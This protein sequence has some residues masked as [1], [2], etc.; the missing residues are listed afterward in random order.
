M[1]SK[2]FV[3]KLENFKQYLR[4]HSTTFNVSSSSSLK[5]LLDDKLN[6]NDKD[7]KKWLV[8]SKFW[9]FSDHR[10]I[11]EAYNNLLILLNAEDE[12][13]P[14]ETTENKSNYF[15]KWDEME[16]KDELFES[17]FKE[18]EQEKLKL[19]K[20]NKVVNLLIRAYS[21]CK[22][23]SMSNLGQLQTIDLG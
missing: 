10:T 22:V 13:K 20:Q 4:K 5:D 19:V 16:K 7:F 21:C 1:E 18:A 23:I 9:K 15:I 8:D 2:N 3:E 6:F 12:N 17:M 14:K 11:E